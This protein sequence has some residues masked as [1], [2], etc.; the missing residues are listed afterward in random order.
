MK[1]FENVNAVKKNLSFADNQLTVV[2][3]NIMSI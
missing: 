2:N 3:F 1:L